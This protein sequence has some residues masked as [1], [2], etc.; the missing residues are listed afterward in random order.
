MIISNIFNKQ[1]KQ[2]IV[3]CLTY[4]NPIGP[5]LNKV[6]NFFVFYSIRVITKFKNLTFSI[7]MN[8]FLPSKDHNQ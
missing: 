5:L 6:T 1:P 2:T 8:S 4:L 7:F 3:H